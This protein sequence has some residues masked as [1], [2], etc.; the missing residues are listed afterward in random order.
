MAE[1]ENLPAR[2]ASRL[3]PL[4]GGV[5]ACRNR[6]R[7]EL[8]GSG[9]GGTVGLGLLAS[10]HLQP[11]V[12]RVRLCLGWAQ[13]SLR[14][15]I[16]HSPE[17]GPALAEVGGMAELLQQNWGVACAWFHDAPLGA[18]P[19]PSYCGL[20]RVPCRAL[21][22]FS[23]WAALSTFMAGS[24]GRRRHSGHRGTAPAGR[25]GGTP[26]GTCRGHGPEGL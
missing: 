18:Q 2:S 6:C 21:S 24:R 7:A 4:R 11:R 17:T 13:L 15:P 12:T 10:H 3:G 26:T 20:G 23:T 8:G 5:P 19:V 14:P 22:C 1:S 16:G 9:A 25:A